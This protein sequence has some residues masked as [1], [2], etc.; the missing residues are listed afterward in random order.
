MQLFNIHYPTINYKK[1]YWVAWRKPQE[2]CIKFNFDGSRSSHK[3]GGGC[4]IRNWE[5]E[6]FQASAFSLETSSILVAEATTIRNWVKAA[7]QAGYTN[8]H[9]KWGNKIRIKAEQGHIQT[10]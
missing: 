9:I 10:P 2:G 1:T 5:G 6:F 3:A 4:V 8:I 7:V